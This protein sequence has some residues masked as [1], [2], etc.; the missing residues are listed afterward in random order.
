M[1]LVVLPSP[2]TGISGSSP[3]AATSASL[4]QYSRGITGPGSCSW[5]SAHHTTWSRSF[6]SGNSRPGT[7]RANSWRIGTIGTVPATISVVLRESDPNVQW[8]SC[9]QYGHGSSAGHSNAPPSELSRTP[10]SPGSGLRRVVARARPSYS[11][12]SVRR[13][14][15]DGSGVPSGIV[16]PQTCRR[17]KDRQGV[18][19]TLVPATDN[20]R[21]VAPCHVVAVVRVED[22]VAVDAGESVRGGVGRERVAEGVGADL[23]D[24]LVV[25]VLV[26]DQREQQV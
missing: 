15:A 18:A 4:R 9:A 23:A 22:E 3:P 24:P 26:V 19:G 11:G 21:S 1:V 6:P 5:F 2:A 16:T 17:T 7:S 20:A 8:S 14:F 13:S 10:G 12:I 25:L